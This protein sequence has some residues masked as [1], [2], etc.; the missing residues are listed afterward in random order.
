MYK[1]RTDKKIKGSNKM[2]SKNKKRKLWLL[3][4]RFWAKDIIEDEKIIA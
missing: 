1:E 2:N 4:E 3:K